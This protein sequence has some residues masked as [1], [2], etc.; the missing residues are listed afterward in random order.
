MKWP[1]NVWPWLFRWCI[2]VSN[3]PYFNISVFLT[4]L[5]FR[6]WL[7]CFVMEIR[8]FAN[9]Q[10]SYIWSTRSHLIWYIKYIWYCCLLRSLI[11]MCSVKLMLFKH[12]Q[13][14]KLFYSLLTVTYYGLVA[15]NKLKLLTLAPIYIYIYIYKCHTAHHVLFG[16]AS[17]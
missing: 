7:F 5:L 1:L 17:K 6:N 8:M 15:N 4:S 12:F 9:T 13:Q 14:H 16:S 2:G 11:S 3:F 10:F